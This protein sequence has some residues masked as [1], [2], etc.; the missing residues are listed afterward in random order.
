M[1]HHIHFELS[2]I[3]YHLLCLVK[4]EKKK[5]TISYPYSEVLYYKKQ[6]VLWD[7]IFGAM[8]TWLSSVNL[9][10]LAIYYKLAIFTKSQWNKP[11]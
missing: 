2:Q 7:A 11:K 3:S 1:S 5:V 9:L 8:A 4:K 6:V 10:S